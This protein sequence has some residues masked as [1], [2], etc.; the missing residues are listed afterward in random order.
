MVKPVRTYRIGETSTNSF[1]SDMV[2]AEYI[3]SN[4]IVVNFPE[5]NWSVRTTYKQFKNGLIKCPYE[6]RTFGVGF[7]GE[8]YTTKENGITTKRYETWRDMIKRCYNPKMILKN[9]TYTEC[10]VC[11]EWHNFQTFAEWYNNNYYEIPGEIMQLDKDILNKNNKVYG[12][13]SC[14]FV[15]ATINKLFVKQ[16][17]QRGEYPVGVYKQKDNNKYRATISINGKNIILGK[18]DTSEEAFDA[19]KTAKENHIKEIA[20]QYKS[21]IPESL[22]Y[23]MY[24]Y[25]IEYND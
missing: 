3:E 2:I 18:F 1:G 13:D 7:L 23:A 20:D 15:P 9:P 11:N 25:E 8:G 21:V 16:Q 10:S 4:N 6:R 5:Y 19:Y 17:R 22:Y 24:E 14:I 12:P